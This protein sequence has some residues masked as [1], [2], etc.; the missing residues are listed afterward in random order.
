[1]ISLKLTRIVSKF[2]LIVSCTLA[3][4]AQKPPI[5]DDPGAQKRIEWWRD[6][7][8][9]MFI[10]YGVY[11][12]LGRGEWVMWNE[13]IPRTEYAKLAQQFHPEPDVADKWAE[14]AKQ[15]GMKYVVLTARHHDGFALFN[16][17]E[18][19]FTA[20]KSSAH[21]DIVAEYVKAVRAQGL[22]VGLYYSPLDWRFPGYFFPDMYLDSADAMR[23]QYQRQI[24]EL[25]SNYGKVDVIWFDGGGD[26]WLGF[27]GVT[28]GRGKRRPKGEP[29]KGKFDWEDNATIAAVR[30]LQPDVLID[31]RT[32]APADFH[33]R[34]GD[35]NLGD[36][37]N[38]YPWE[39]CTTITEGSWG[40][41]SNVKVKPLKG[42]IDIIVGAVGRD[43][44]V[45]LNV[46]P[47]PNGEVVPEQAE[48][49]RQI[50]EWM[51]LHGESIYGTRGGPWLPGSYGVSTHKRRIVYIHLLNPPG[52]GEL[53]MPRLPLNVESVSLLNGASLKFEQAG[54]NLKISLPASGM[55]SIDTVIRLKLAQSWTSLATVPAPGSVV[56][57]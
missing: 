18:S 52:S 3:A 26:S 31:D 27:G 7:R 15:G 38:R 24:R 2:A 51:K 36:F 35:R 22:G 40:Y 4:A 25:A 49:V 19:D 57:Y 5:V 9:G 6:A 21:E 37:E 20:V 11:S 56:V 34:E 43:G 54:E 46:G 1:M 33:T 45:L 13:Q 12:I 29:Y 55:E 42:L 14:L 47:L 48:R 8:F 39:L 16:D 30:K 10:H 50:G 53:T 17:P 44:N 23:T 32:D 28:Y 41:N